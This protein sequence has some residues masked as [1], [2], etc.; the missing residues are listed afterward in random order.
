MYF[1]KFCIGRNEPGFIQEI[2]QWVNSIL[3][4]HTYFQ[5]VRYQESRVQYVKPLLDIEKNDSTCM[6]GIFETGGINKT[7]IAKAI[8]NSIASLTEGSCFLENIRET[9]CSNSTSFH[10]SHRAQ[11]E[12][13]YL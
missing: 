7:T 5:V 11:Y 10:N 3:V 12:F 2:I 9:S 4:K 13:L 8:Y 6:V 1:Y